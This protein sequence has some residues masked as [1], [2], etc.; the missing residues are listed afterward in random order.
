MSR[1]A[2]LHCHSN[3]SFLDGASHPGDLVRRAA[4]LGYE[5]LAITDHDGFYGAARFR[6]AAAEVGL[7]TVYGVEVGM[8]QHPLPAA[9]D[10]LPARSAGSGKREAESGNPRRGRTHRTH[11]SKPMALPPTDHLVLLAPDPR[12]YAAISRLVTRAQFRGEKDR[13]VYAA[14]DLAEASAFGKLV[15]LT[16]CHQGAVPRAAAAGDLAGAISAAARLRE[17]FPG[18]LHLEVSDHRMPGDDLR[19]DVLAEVSARLHLP[20]VATNDVHYHDRSEADLAE[21]LAAI[22]G[23]RDLDA[24]H[25][26]WPAT[27]ERHLKSPDEMAGR[28]ARYRGATERAADLGRS[29][30]FD[31]RLVAPRLPDFPM[32]GAF[33]DEMDYLR[34]LTLEGARRIYPGNG[35]G[36]VDPAAMARLDH[37]L[38][39]IGSLGFPGYFLIVWDIVRFAESRDI[40]CQIRGSGADSAVCRCLEITRVDPIRLG[41]PFERFLS[42]ERGRPPDID[43]DFEA[44][45]R[46]EVIQYCYGRYGRERA[47]MVANVIT[48]RARSV[49]QDV[50][51]AFGLTQAQVNGLTKYLDTRD[52]A[53]ID[54][55]LE[56]PPGPT[57]DFILDVC[58]RL[59]GFPRHLGI[60]SGG[61]VIADRPLWETVPLEWGRMEDRSV[62]QWDKDDCASMGIVKFDL[63]AL[64]MLNALH[65]TM[66]MIE[67]AHGVG[68]DLA[69]IPQE[70]VIYQMLTRADTVGM[71]QVESRAQMATLP[72]MKP[73]TF[74]D[75]AIE[76]ALIRPGPIQ[77]HSV[78]PYLRRRNGEE[79]V[80]YPHPS[81]EPVLA[82][83]L[84]VPVFQEQLMEIA[85]I[86]AGYSP[87]QSD[88]LRQAMTHKRSDEEMEKLRD[89]TIAGMAGQGIT[90]AAADEIWDKLQGFASFGFPESHSVSF[91]YIVYMSAWLKYHWPAEFLAGLLNAQPM[92]FYS[93]NSLVQDAVRH[94]VVVL[95]PDVNESVFDCSIVPWNADPADLATYYGVSWRRGR[96]AVEDPVRMAAAVRMGLRYVRDLGETEITRIEA[97]R[98]VG[99]AFTGVVDL[100]QRTGLPVGALE[101]LAAAG[102]LEPLGVTRRQGLWAAGALAGMGPGRLPLAAGTE[103]PQL[104]VMGEVDR[105][106][107]DLWAT[108]VS[109]RHPAEFVRERLIAEGCVTV[110]EALGGMLAGRRIKVG[111]VVT[112]RQRPSTAKG[113]IFI[114]LEDETGLLNV[115]VTPDVWSAQR[116]VARRSVGLMIDGS[117][118]HR[119]GVTNLIA[120]R[121]TSWPV[122][123]PVENIAS[124]DW[125][126][127]GG[128][129]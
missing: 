6:I 99:G 87:G 108:G 80:R 119:D 11:G 10:P 52:P 94:G 43:V 84:G 97:A 109:V 3:F 16:G 111:G 126:S 105:A 39:V 63:L 62:L 57:A 107:A 73:K 40:L 56:L 120:R 12:G 85:R 66:D 104:G 58:R 72:R 103:S 95:G 90:G 81:L 35:P 74:Y 121:F 70:P 36:N 23:R 7:P 76:V 122:E 88:R 1:Y 68:I 18:R 24:G 5:A 101:G 71:F 50:G 26:H 37:E 82:K 4:E 100:A 38:G 21:V 114:N 93:P 118:E 44:E 14:A 45:R 55:H 34:H 47:A 15:A 28:M 42:A 113:V 29:L 79:P 25:G 31:L 53:K 86:C 77:G 27:D 102:A 125:G 106:R 48:Y 69:R 83:T 2:E 124:R 49:L 41:L 127:G 8:P 64:G 13:P 110:A 20:L 61:M 32:P 59:D 17:A 51:K 89:E 65:L 75:L 30:A 129:R 22:G 128:R 9:R 78:H 92:G 91:A 19:N 117:L 33:R 46:E 98:L 60:H 112:H 123:G 67:E 116:D 54:Q 115:I 96:G